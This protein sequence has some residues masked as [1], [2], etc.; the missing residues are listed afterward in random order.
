VVTVDGEN[1]WHISNAITKGSFSDQP[2]TYTSCKVA[3][4]TGSALFNVR[5][6]ANLPLPGTYATSDQ[7]YWRVSFKSATG[8]AQSG[9]NIELAS[10]AKYSTWRRSR[11]VITDAGNGF[12]LTAIDVFGNITSGATISIFTP[13]ASVLSYTEFHTI[14]TRILFVDGITD[15]GNNIVGGNDV[16]QVYLNG[17]LIHTGSTNEA[18][19]YVSPASAT[20]G[21]APPRR[22]ATDCLMFRVSD[23]AVTGTSGKGFYFSDVVVSNAFPVA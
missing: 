10:N 1:V 19:Y 15:L 21:L 22:Q 3:S 2:M 16:L 8:V 17:T 9:L 6:P 23:P 5:S 12:N 18:Y 7:F 4:E 14:E 20:E 11:L 13:I